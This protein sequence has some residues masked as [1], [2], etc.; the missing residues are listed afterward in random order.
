MPQALIAAA[1]TYVV[2]VAINV[3]IGFISNFAV[4]ALFGEDDP[5]S[6]EVTRR[7]VTSGSPDAARDI[8]YGRVRKGGTVSFHG[9]THASA[10]PSSFPNQDAYVYHYVVALAGHECDAIEEIWWGDYQLTLDGN[11]DEQGTYAGVMRV[12]QHLGAWDQAADAELIASIT[13]LDSNF[14]GRNVCYLYFQLLGSGKLGNKKIEN[15]SAVIRGRKIYQPRNPAHV[16]TDPDTWEY[17]SNPVDCAADLYTGAQIRDS[18][19]ALIPMTGF[20]VD[21]SKRVD[22]DKQ[23]IFSAICDETITLTVGTQNRFEC[24]GVLSANEGS[25]SQMSKLLSSMG[26]RAINFGG[27]YAFMPAYARTSVM[28]FGQDNFLSRVNVSLGSEASNIYTAATGLYIDAERNFTATNS[29]LVVS[30]TF[31]TALNGKRRTRELQLP[32][33]ANHTQVERLCKLAIG[34]SSQQKTFK[35]LLDFSALALEVGDV[36]SVT[37]DVA[38]WVSKQFEVVA[39]KL[40][41]DPLKDQ[42]GVEV[43]LK[44]YDASIFS[45]S[46]GEQTDLNAEVPSS[47]PSVALVAAPVSLTV[48]QSNYFTI[49]FVTL[50]AGAVTHAYPVRYE[51]R[52][53][54]AS[55]ATYETLALQDSNHVDVAGLPYGDYVFEVRAVN[56]R[57]VPS[58]WVVQAASLSSATDI[59]RPTYFHVVDGLSDNEWVGP[60]LRLDW[61]DVAI[62][63]Q[64]LENTDAAD[65]GNNDAQFRSYEL[66]LWAGTLAAHTVLI[67][68]KQHKES[69]FTLTLDQNR[70]LSVAAGLTGPQRNIVAKVYTV[71]NNGQ[72]SS[73]SVLECF[74]AAPPTATGIAI[75]PGLSALFVDRVSGVDADFAGTIVRYSTSSGFDAA[76]GGGTIGFQSSGP[77]QITGLAAGTTYYLQIADYDAFGLTGLNWSSEF[78][79]A[80]VLI[81]ATE[82]S[83]GGITTP[84]LA[85][86]AV[87]AEKINVTSLDAVSGTM[88]ILHT[89]EVRFPETGTAKLHIKATGANPSILLRTV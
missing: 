50:T 29:N 60:D 59:P 55:A 34:D 51:F 11:G 56:T 38:G 13:E 48:D 21:P 25:A 2:D 37:H 27:K 22:W 84:K 73:A 53:R 19:G 69:Q 57:G 44:E 36:I 71:L 45:W 52:Y 43:S 78:T 1:I 85:T 41:I 66:E 49:G 75:T 8:V 46:S 89:G 14:R 18:T 80:T 32:F 86:N 67:S 23:E 28:S 68:R 16:L 17:S 83:D 74:N 64:G 15:V 82:I 33:V 58:A 31:E 42:N 39:W 61:N 88:G 76:A 24:H 35:L 20:D 70:A 30:S 79:A 9:V 63:A 65:T 26:G 81:G 72:R 87:T 40:K 4:N 6:N 62:S 3:A 7:K 10:T 47:I 5:S 12:T 54:L 77:I